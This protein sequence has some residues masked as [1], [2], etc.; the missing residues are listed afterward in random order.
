MGIPEKIITILATSGFS[1]FTI[2]NFIMLI[3]V[4]VLLY[5]AIVK[6]C[7]P[8]LL[9]PIAFGALLANIPLTGISEPGGLLYYIGLGLKYEIYPLLIFMG[10]GA[11]TDFGPLLA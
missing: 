1:S 4:G 5:L 6:K 3:I 2:G 7:E 8:L 9:L 11:M 10:V